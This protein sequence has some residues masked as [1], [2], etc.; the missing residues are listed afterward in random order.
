MSIP[1]T[2]VNSRCVSVATPSVAKFSRASYSTVP[3]FHY[4]NPNPQVSGPKFKGPR[5]MA[6]IERSGSVEKFQPDA[7]RFGKRIVFGHK[8]TT[9]EILEDHLNKIKQN[10]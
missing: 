9:S 2:V 1:T 6:P 3:S 5:E 7:L 4:A 8:A 10:K